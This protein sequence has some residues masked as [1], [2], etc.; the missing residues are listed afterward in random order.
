MS[1]LPTRCRN[2][3]CPEITTDDYCEEHRDE[4]WAGY[5]DGERNRLSSAERG[6][7]ATWRKA[8]DRYI[9]RNPLCERCDSR[10]YTEP[11]ELVHHIV[12]LEDG[13]A[14]LDPDNLKSLCYA[15]H[16]IIHEQ[17]DKSD[18]QVHLVCGPPASG[19]S[20]FVKKNMR[21]GD[22]VLDVDL[23]WQAL[24]RQPP[25]KKPR[26]LLDPVLRTRDFLLDYIAETP[27]L[28]RVW[29]VAGAPEAEAREKLKQKLGA[30]TT[31]LLCDEETSRQR[32][33]A[34]DTR[35]D[36]QRHL[37]N[38]ADWWERFEVSDEDDRV[39]EDHGQ[40]RAA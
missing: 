39:I 24:S 12:P 10:G 37:D 25:Y 4:K 6:Y 33:R 18:K 23:L 16:S 27:D 35:T 9:K 19:K 21:P 14:R 29:V 26:E 13:G 7:D 30:E 38:L 32:I 31:L 40:E 2:K 17:M 1:V 36:T 5:D 28:G 3:R 15:C 22:L 34:S 20:S 11:A 8:R